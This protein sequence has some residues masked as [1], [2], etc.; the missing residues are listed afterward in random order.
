MVAMCIKSST[1]KDDNE[2][3]KGIEASRGST[4]LERGRLGTP[5]LDAKIDTAGS[6]DIDGPRLWQFGAVGSVIAVLS[7]RN[8]LFDL[9]FPPRDAGAEMLMR[10][11]GLNTSARLQLPDAH[12]LVVGDG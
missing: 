6:D 10:I 7:G 1:R 9:G 12:R 2:G 8:R 4:R 3:I 5:D 11:D